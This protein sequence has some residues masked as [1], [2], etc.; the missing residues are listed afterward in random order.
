[1]F[2]RV[3][4]AQA[5]ENGFD[6]LI[7][8]AN[9]QLPGARQRPGSAGFFLLVDDSAGRVINIS[10]WKTREEMEAFT[11]RVFQT[12][13]L[14]RRLENSRRPNRQMRMAFEFKEEF[15]LSRKSPLAATM[16]IDRSTFLESTGNA[17]APT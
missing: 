14:P 5:G 16:N 4:T 2:A 15:D 17:E 9:Q 3:I 10:L 12:P 11:T 6:N 1:M 13:A 8:L 7:R